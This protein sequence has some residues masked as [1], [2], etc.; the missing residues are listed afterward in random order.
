MAALPLAE[1]GA[2]RLTVRLY[3]ESYSLHS[4]GAWHA[5]WLTIG[6]QTYYFDTEAIDYDGNT[7]STNL[8]GTVAASIDTANLPATAELSWHFQGTYGDVKL[9]SI[10]ATGT[11]G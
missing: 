8:L 6:G 7:L 5:G 9:D 10:T 3:A 1:G 4:Q 11:I 2:A